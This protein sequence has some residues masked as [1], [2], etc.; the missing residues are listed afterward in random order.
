MTRD[1]LRAELAPLRAEIEAMRRELFDL[2]SRLGDRLLTPNEAASRL[3][4]S[5]RTLRS[6]EAE[7]KLTR[8]NVEGRPRYALSDFDAFVRRRR[9]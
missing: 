3:G 5:T 1:D 4:V 8:A 6:Y 2:S 9:R 7:G